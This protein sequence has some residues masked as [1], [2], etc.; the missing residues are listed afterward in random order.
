[1]TNHR[2]LMKNERKRRLNPECPDFFF[3]FLEKSEDGR[4]W[5]VSF[6]KTKKTTKQ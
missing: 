4:Y 1:M 5:F 2:T 6:E 3:Y